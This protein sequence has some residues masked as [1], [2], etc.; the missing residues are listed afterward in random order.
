MPRARFIPDVA[1][2][3]AALRSQGS[4]HDHCIYS[5]FQCS[6]NT[7]SSVV[8]RS[9]V[10]LKV[11]PV[12][13]WSRDIFRE[14]LNLLQIERV[15]GHLEA[16]LDLEIMQKGA[17]KTAHPGQVSTT[18]PNK[19]PACFSGK[20]CVKQV[21]SKRIRGSIGRLGGAEEYSKIVKE[22]ICLDWG[23]IL[24]NLTYQFIE[25]AVADYGE[26]LGGIPDLRFV[27]AMLAQETEREKSYLIEEWINDTTE[28]IKYINNGCPVPCVQPDAPEEVHRIAEFLCFAQ[29]VQYNE[30]NGYVYTSDYQG[31]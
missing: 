27:R 18:E 20:I 9:R 3:R 10:F 8:R 11:M 25:E 4:S 7:D 13:T 31:L 19:I 30:T 14:K 24:L 17:F 5:L 15:Q 28:F 22:L 1:Q 2:M 16:N 23:A 29:H 21:Y 26:P 12:R 6:Q